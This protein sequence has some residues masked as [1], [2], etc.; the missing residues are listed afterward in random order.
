[1]N[2]STPMTLK[3]RPGLRLTDRAVW[4]LRRANPDLRLE[5]T[6]QGELVVM[7]PAGSDSGGR[8]S[9]LTTRL[10]MW[11][12]STGR[13]KAFDSSAGFTLPNGAVRSPDASWIA[14]ERWNTLTPEQKKT[15]A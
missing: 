3:F 8:N 14:Q 1:M 12:E 15:F 10:G 11:V 6:A 2:E 5:R 13:E 9:K 7:A 4:K